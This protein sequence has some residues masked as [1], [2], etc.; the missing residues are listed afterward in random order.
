MALF[1][2]EPGDLGVVVT[3][4]EMTARPKPRPIPPS[5]LR[6]LRWPV[7]TPE[8]YRALF[9]RVGRHWLWASRLAM[10]DVALLSVI[11]DPRI[12]I[13]AI[14]DPRGTEIGILELDFREAAQCE[15]S[16]FGLIPE[17]TGQNHG[18]NLMPQVIPLAWKSDIQRVW[19]HTC[20]LDHPS[21]LGFYQKQG[22]TAYR[23][24]FESF[25]D[26]RRLRLLPAD[27]APN[28]PKL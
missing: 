10:D 14:L 16:F 24:H 19:L 11:R 5:P 7:P 23:R 4:L 15:L 17:W 22:F 13:R 25:P 21:A 8:K 3:S 12:E 20:T 2:V 1:A 18:R 6:L 27:S 9:R 28:V 26:P